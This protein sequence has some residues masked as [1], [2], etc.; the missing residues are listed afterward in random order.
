M[1]KRLESQNNGQ[2]SRRICALKTVWHHMSCVTDIEININSVLFNE[3]Q[4]EETEREI[5]S[6]HKTKWDK[7]A[8]FFPVYFDKMDKAGKF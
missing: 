4:T 3:R 1:D 7:Q 5:L 2:N 6:M 8:C